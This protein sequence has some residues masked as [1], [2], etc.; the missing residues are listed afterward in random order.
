MGISGA[1]QPTVGEKNL[2]FAPGPRGRE[3]PTRWGL[4]TRLQSSERFME[5]ISNEVIVV[6]STNKH[7]VGFRKMGG[8][9]IIQGKWMTG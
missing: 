2:M 7:L 9:Q 1:I 3:H 4:G 5:D 8:A 6:S